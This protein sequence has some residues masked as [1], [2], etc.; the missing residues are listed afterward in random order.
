MVAAADNLLG[1]GIYTPSEAALYARVPAATLVRWIFGNK[2]GDPVLRRQLID[3]RPDEKVVTFLD[4]VQALAVRVMRVQYQIPLDTIRKA[5]ETARE[6]Y[7]VQYPLAMKHTTYLYGRDVVIKV[8]DK[9]V[10][11]SPGEHKH[12][13][14]LKEIVEIYMRDLSWDARGLAASYRAFSVAIGKRSYEVSM[15][16]TVRF[17]EPMVSSSGY[18]AQAL[19]EAATTEGSVE[20]AARAYGVAP[21]EVEVACR[22]YDHIQ[23]N[24]AA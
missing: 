7:Q 17:G 11:V 15:N 2:M 10:Q 16:P 9:I 24:T 20:A 18:S 3:N 6:S 22:Y 1:V 19:W 23:L 12:G 13:L 21:E 4:F 5:I 14:M 8:G